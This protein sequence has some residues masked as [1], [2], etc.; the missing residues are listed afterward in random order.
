MF[1]LTPAEILMATDAE[2]NEVLGLRK[3]AP[4]REKGNGKPGK[5]KK[6]QLQELR[7][8]LA[9][10]KWGEEVDEEADAATGKRWKGT[11]QVDGQGR[12]EA[13][14]RKGKKERQRAKQDQQSA[15]AAEDGD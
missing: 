7:Q 8:K 14:K 2:L 5:A 3:I 11:A 10:R 15:A 9:K 6:K 4:Y 12:G 1:D 13:K